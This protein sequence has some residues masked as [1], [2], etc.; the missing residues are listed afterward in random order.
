M[1]FE[2][3]IKKTWDAGHNQPDFS[4][5]TRHEFNAS[6][7]PEAIKNARKLV[8]EVCDPKAHYQ[9]HAELRTISPIWETEFRP[10]PN[11]GMTGEMRPTVVAHFE[12]R[13]LN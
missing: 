13:R 2:V 8:L 9:F 1:R 12:E 10:T 7:I 4:Q 11:V 6:D 3:I 5:E